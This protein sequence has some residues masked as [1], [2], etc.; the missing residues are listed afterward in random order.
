MK[1]QFISPNTF[2]NVVNAPASFNLQDYLCRRLGKTIAKAVELPLHTW[3]L[4][5][6]FA[7]LFYAIEL[8]TYRAR[9]ELPPACTM[10]MFDALGMSIREWSDF[11]SSTSSAVAW[12]EMLVCRYDQAG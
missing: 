11:S 1:T 12:M 5:F 2:G 10:P 3:L 9:P 6:V 7:L 4:L 8:A